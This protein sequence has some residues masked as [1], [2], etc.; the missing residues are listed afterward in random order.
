MNHTD[1]YFVHDRI[2]TTLREREVL[3]LRDLREEVERLT[4]YDVEEFNAAFFELFLLEIIEI[5]KLSETAAVPARKV[6]YTLSVAGADLFDALTRLMPRITG[7]S[8]GDIMLAIVQSRACSKQELRDRLMF[9]S[10]DRYL[11]ELHFSVV[12]WVLI[13]RERIMVQHCLG[14]APLYM[15]GP[16]GYKRLRHLG[17]NH[18]SAQNISMGE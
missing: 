13:R 4:R 16:A 12:L 15:L 18:Q 2:V 5:Y 7:W 3:N 11:S 17:S 14:E 1:R 9:V 8:C 10:G 6:Q